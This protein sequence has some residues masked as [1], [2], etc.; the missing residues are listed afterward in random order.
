M[1]TTEDAGN[2]LFDLADSCQS[3]AD[4]IAAHLVDASHPLNAAFINQLMDQQGKLRVCAHSLRLQAISQ[5]V[6]AN[7]KVQEQLDQAAKIA[8]TAI[9]KIQTV[10]DTIALT[11]ALLQLAGAI[12]LAVSTGNPAG[13]LPAATNLINVAKPLVSK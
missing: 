6:Q 3:A 7:S 4:E 11:G 2:E 12:A 1:G 13:I 9:K 8:T 5:I 10:Q